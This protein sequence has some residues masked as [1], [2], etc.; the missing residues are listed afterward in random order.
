MGRPQ[1]FS[2]MRKL[3]IV[4]LEK[5]NTGVVNLYGFIRNY[6]AADAARNARGLYNPADMHWIVNQRLI[7]MT[8]FNF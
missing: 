2:A 8:K 5:Q 1:I 7:C 6:I 4:A 3:E